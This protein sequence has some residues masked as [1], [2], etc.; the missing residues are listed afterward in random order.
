[1]AERVAANGLKYFAGINAC[2]RRR[3]TGKMTLLGLVGFKRFSEDF[4]AG[5]RFGMPAPAQGPRAPKRLRRDYRPPTLAGGQC[6][7]CV[8]LILSRSRY[9]T[10]GADK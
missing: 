4:G 1:M 5:W 8:A 7:I 10:M 6:D 9:L 2:S 3:F